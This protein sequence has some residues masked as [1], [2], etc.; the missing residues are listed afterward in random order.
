MLP[1]EAMMAVE[2]LGLAL[3]ALLA[4]SRSLVL[5]VDLR[6]L[7]ALLP[8]ERADSLTD[9]MQPRDRLKTRRWVWG[10]MT[11]AW[12]VLATLQTAHR[13]RRYFNNLVLNIRQLPIK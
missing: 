2:A 6:P 7:C 8:Q 5:R 1:P 13:Q 4:V 11:F 12:I 3:P 10:F 9:I